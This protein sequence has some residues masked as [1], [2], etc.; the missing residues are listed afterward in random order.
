MTIIFKLTIPIYARVFRA[1]LLQMKRQQK[2]VVYI[3]KAYTGGVEVQLHSSLTS[4]LSL[5]KELENNGIGSKNS[6]SVP[7]R[8]VQ[9][10]GSCKAVRCANLC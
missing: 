6:R 9:F 5:L 2:V 7:Y 10:D 3:T 8:C 1:Q 4:T